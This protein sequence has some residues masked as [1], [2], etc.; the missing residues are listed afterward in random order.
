MVSRTPALLVVAGTCALLSSAYADCL[1]KGKQITID[2]GSWYEYC[3]TGMDGS[4]NVSYYAQFH[5]VNNDAYTTTSIVA[6]DSQHTGHCADSASGPPAWQTYV[7]RSYHDN[8]VHS[9]QYYDGG[10]S[11][12]YLATQISFRIG[13]TTPGSGSQCQIQLDQ[14]HQCNGQ[15]CSSDTAHPLSAATTT[16]NAAAGVAVM[17]IAGNLT[18]VAQTQQKAAMDTVQPVQTAPSMSFIHV[19]FPRKFF[20]SQ[21]RTN[22]PNGDCG[23]DVNCRGDSSTSPPGV[24]RCTTHNVDPT[25]LGSFLVTDTQAPGYNAMCYVPIGSTGTYVAQYQYGGQGVG[26]VGL[27][28]QA[29]ASV[30]A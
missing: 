8:F 18:E 16:E 2:A 30:L 14:L 27:C 17:D 3:C 25:K 24:D 1:D 9:E 13:C 7:A 15:S 5:S 12:V 28:Q 23:L 21:C 10:S 29:E 22:P 26:G 6:D 4:Q 11:G 20:V 19:N